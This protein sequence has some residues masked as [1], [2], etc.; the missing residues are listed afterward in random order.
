M[1]LNGQLHAILPLNPSAGPPL[2]VLKMVRVLSA[3]PTEVSASITRPTPS[4]SS[5]TMAAKML[6]CGSGARAVSES[7]RL[8]GA[9][10]GAC[11][12]CQAK[13]LLQP[14]HVISGNAKAQGHRGAAT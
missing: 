14:V 9:S 4:S 13:Y 10:S 1:P 8:C 2:S 7:T 12:D 6:R 5:E 3:I 11:T